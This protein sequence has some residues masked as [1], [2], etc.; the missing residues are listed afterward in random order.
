MG[1]AVIVERRQTGERCGFL[2]ADVSELGHADDERESDSLLQGRISE[3][4][5]RHSPEATA[6]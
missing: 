3:T 2:A 1:S 6:A 5:I 4:V